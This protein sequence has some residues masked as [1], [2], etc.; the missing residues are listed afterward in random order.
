M[1]LLVREDP[2]QSVES[3]GLG[4]C[5]GQTPSG[6]GLC[7]REP[8]LLRAPTRCAVAVDHIARRAAVWASHIE[9]GG[10]RGGDCAA[11][12]SLRRQHGSTRSPGCGLRHTGSPRS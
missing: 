10:L 4:Q 11:A 6:C 5:A 1:R 8:S 3:G 9:S 12:P 2:G 7:A